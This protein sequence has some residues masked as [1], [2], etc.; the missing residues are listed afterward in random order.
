MSTPAHPRI[1]L[2]VYLLARML[3]TVVI[4]APLLV[5][6][7]AWPETWRSVVHNGAFS[8]G[9]SLLKGRASS[10]VSVPVCCTATSSALSG[11]PCPLNLALSLAQ[12]SSVFA[13]DLGVPRHVSA[14]CTEVNLPLCPI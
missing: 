5:F 11:E 14:L 7:S 10:C 8:R 9:Q 1:S 2:P 13:C 3:Y 12:V 6:H 4:R